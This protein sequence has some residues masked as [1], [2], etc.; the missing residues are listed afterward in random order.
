MGIPV[1]EPTPGWQWFDRDPC[2][3]NQSLA[4]TSSK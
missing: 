1:F 2:F 4:K 3:P